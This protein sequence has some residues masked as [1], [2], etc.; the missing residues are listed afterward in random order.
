MVDARKYLSASFVTLKDVAEGPL[1]AVIGRVEEGKYEKLNLIFTDGTALSLNAGNTRTMVKAYGHK[2]EAWPG[3]TVEL[4]AGETEYQGKPQP[5]VAL[6][7][8]SPPLAAAA[9][10]AADAA[11][12][13]RGRGDSMD[14]E[15]T[16]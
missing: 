6:M 10:A 4:S 2:T 16:F 14:D 13:R 3:L 9:K 5:S 11:P 12:I 8:I 7:P 1:Q 15:I